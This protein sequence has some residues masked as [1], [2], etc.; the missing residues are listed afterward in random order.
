MLPALGDIR[1]KIWTLAPLSQLRRYRSELLGV[2]QLHSQI[3]L[4]SHQTE[5]HLQTE[6]VAELQTQG[7][8]RSVALPLLQP[9]PTMQTDPPIPPLRGGSLTLPRTH[10]HHPQQGVQDQELRRELTSMI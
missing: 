10:S 9:L 8:R 3:C 4:H 2:E 5:E 6:V 7:R 1:S